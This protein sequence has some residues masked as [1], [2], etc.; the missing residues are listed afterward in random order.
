MEF[1][2]P[3]EGKDFLA[4]PLGHPG[5]WERTVNYKYGLG[6]AAEARQK[7]LREKCALAGAA[8]ADWLAFADFQLT[9]FGR[10]REAKERRLVILRSEERFIQTGE[11][12]GQPRTDWESHLENSNAASS[13]RAKTRAINKN[14][15]FKISKIELMHLSFGLTPPLFR[16]PPPL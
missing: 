7:E 13:K 3:D 1:E 16:A 12:A 4:M 14:V 2:V 6:R 8:A 9:Y 5:D 10:T 15:R 11:A